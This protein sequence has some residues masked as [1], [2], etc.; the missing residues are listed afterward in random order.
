MSST[1]EKQ[2][3]L[4]IYTPKSPTYYLQVE[5]KKYKILKAIKIVEFLKCAWEI[6]TIPYKMTIYNTN[7]PFNNDNFS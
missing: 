5:N 1:F 4:N 3:S 7:W 6:H 2:K